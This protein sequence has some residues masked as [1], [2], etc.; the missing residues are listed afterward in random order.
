MFRPDG[1]WAPD[2]QISQNNTNIG[3]MAGPQFQPFPQMQPQNQMQLQPQLINPVQNTMMMG[4][5]PG[6]GAPSNQMLGQFGGR[7]NVQTHP[8]QDMGQRPVGMGPA[9]T[10]NNPN[11]PPPLQQVYSPPV[12]QQSITQSV[13]NTDPQ[14]VQNYLR[15][16]HNTPQAGQ[17]NA[18]RNPAGMQGQ[19]AQ[20]GFQGFQQNGVQSYGQGAVQYQQPSNQGFGKVNTLAT[21]GQNNFS[22]LGAGTGGMAGAPSYQQ[23]GYVQGFTNSPPAPAKNPYQ[24]Q[25]PAQKTGE[26]GSP[27][28]KGEGNY[29]KNNQNQDQGGGNTDTPGQSSFSDINVK[30]DIKQGDTQLKEFLDSLGVYDYEYKDPKYGE[31]RRI[32]P[33]A[34]E[35]EKTPLGKAA[36]STNVEGYK[37]VDYGKLGGTMLASLAMLNHKYNE[38]ENSIKK[39]L[40]SKGKIK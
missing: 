29:N 31:G 6:P 23:G 12:P 26:E 7:M 38:L 3:Q 11:I 8:F 21:P 22:Q 9:P 15:A 19:G 25:T 14:A 18:W 5:Q 37:I 16:L 40:I 4:G 30:Q 10:S 13:N 39:G 35:I 27:G 33:M 34:Q 28:P 1:S 2:Q 17:S 36:I 24:Y 20:A 32:S